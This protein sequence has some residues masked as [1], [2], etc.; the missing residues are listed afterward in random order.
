MPEEEL[1]DAM[2]I[3]LGEQGMNPADYVYLYKKNEIVEG[4]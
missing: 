2:Q 3:E 4:Q 1:Q